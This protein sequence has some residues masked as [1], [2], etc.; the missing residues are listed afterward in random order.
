MFSFWLVQLL[1]F[2]QTKQ[3]GYLERGEAP[4]ASLDILLGSEVGQLSDFIKST[5][6]IHSVLTDRLDQL[7]PSQQLAI[8]VPSRPCNRCLVLHPLQI[9]GANAAGVRDLSLFGSVH[10][11]MLGPYRWKRSEMAESGADWER[12]G[13]N[14]V[15]G[16]AACNLPFPHLC[17]KSQGRVEMS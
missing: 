9:A 1:V 13:N 11:L 10:V 6:S 16:L 8:K 15:H 3:Q 4:A 7:R 2:I 5:V 17:T 14:S 12:D